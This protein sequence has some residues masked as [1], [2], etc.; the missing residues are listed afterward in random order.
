M[1]AKWRS[2]R[3]TAQQIRASLLASAT[4]ATFG[5]SDG[6][7]QVAPWPIVPEPCPALRHRATLPVRHGSTAFEDTCCRACIRIRAL[8]PRPSSSSI[9]MTRYCS[10]LRLPWGTTIPR[11]RRIARNWLIRAVRS[12]TK[13]SLDRCS[14]FMSKSR[15]GLCLDET[16]G[17][18][19]C[20]LR[21]P[22]G[23]TIVV[24]LRLD[25]RPHV[26]R[27]SSGGRACPCAR[28]QP[29]EMIGAA[30]SFSI[31]T[32]HGGNLPTKSMSVSLLLR[33]RRTTAPT[34]SKPTLLHTFF[35][36]STP[37]TA[38]FINLHDPL[39][40]LSLR[41]DYLAGRRGGPFHNN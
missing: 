41:R 38:I 6:R 2:P 10:S 23:V 30:T 24:L 4:A 28:E 35:P 40:R 12:P 5:H 25:V 13:R 27:R 3:S 17:R 20:R 22:L 34:S 18:P 33:R 29:T 37:S 11:S 14:I 16:H 9:S 21:Y 36:R 19:R 1:A 31:A 26:F 32:M 15:L 8:R 7:G 39:L